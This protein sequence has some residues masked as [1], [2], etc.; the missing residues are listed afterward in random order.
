MPSK[1]LVCEFC[2]TEMRKCDIAT[3]IKAK[4]EKELVALMLKEYSE[5]SEDKSHTTITKLMRHNKP[6]SIPIYSELYPDA[7]YFFGV[8]PMMFLEEDDFDTVRS[9]INSE[10]NMEAHIEYMYELMNKIGLKD[11]AEYNIKIEVRSPEISLLKKQYS[12]ATR[13]IAEQEKENEML[14]NIIAQQKHNYNELKEAIDMGFGDE[15][16]QMKKDM[17][18]YKR[19][20]NEQDKEIAYYRNRLEEY[21]HKVEEEIT[22]IRRASSKERD[23]LYENEEKLLA[24]IKKLKENNEKI[25]LKIKQEAQKMLEKEKEKKKAEKKKVK[26]AL[27]KAKALAALEND[28]S[29]SDSDSDSE[30]SGSDSD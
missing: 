2:Q 13:K 1:D 14:K 25:K 21:N 24:E 12:E 16:P 20:I 8:K 26:K 10:K 18:F 4:H 15:L 7:R 6:H 9:Y 22:N 23:M 27:K 11:M 30:S 28:S 17:D 5:A 3:H 29:S 19:T